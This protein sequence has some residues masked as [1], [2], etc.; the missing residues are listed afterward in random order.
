V[1]FTVF[2]HA[3]PF[4]AVYLRGTATVHQGSLAALRDEV[5]PIVAHYVAAEDIESTID[6][7]DSGQPKALVTIAPTSIRAHANL[8]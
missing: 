7:N 5:R 1:A 4:R 3:A 6:G 8:G 2:E